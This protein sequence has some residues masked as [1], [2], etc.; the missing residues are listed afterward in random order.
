MDITRKTKIINN[1]SGYMSILLGTGLMAIAVTSFFDT[2]GVVTGGVTGVAII[3]KKL[4]NAPM[5]VVN[6]CI[7]IPLFILGYK[8]LDKE[9]FIRSLV[10]TVGLT[11][12]LGIIPQLNIRTG[13]LLVDVIFGAV[14]MGG[15]LGLI[16]GAYASSGGTDFM[17]TMINKKISYI[18]V[19]KIMAVIDAV[20]VLAG[21]GVFGIYKGMYALIAIY[22]TTKVSDAVVAGPGKAAMMY[23]ITN[24][25]NEIMDYITGTV[26]RGATWIQVVGA[27]TKNSHKMII[28]VVSD[29]E[30]V[31]IKQQIYK[32]DKNAIC[33]I[34]EI[35]EAFGEGFTKFH[36]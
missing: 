32:I 6:G 15:G 10:A 36:E 7:N 14:I 33:F 18:S 23:I 4:F 13:D 3:F 29:R 5:W 34:G 21:A 20:I 12:F 27:Y 9:T 31:K 19:P 26:G 8:I 24:S 22:I 2:T 17:A 16:L 11:F 28:C 30:M 35:R 1:I 25:E